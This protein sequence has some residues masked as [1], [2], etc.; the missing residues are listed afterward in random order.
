MLTILEIFGL[1]L[2]AKVERPSVQ[3]ASLAWASSVVA[4]AAGFVVGVFMGLAIAN[5]RA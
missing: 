5:S 4:G 2:F 1:Y 3:P